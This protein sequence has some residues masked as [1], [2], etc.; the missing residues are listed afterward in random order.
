[1]LV[2]YYVFDDIF[3]LPLLRVKKHKHK[4]SKLK[5][6]RQTFF[7]IQ[8]QGCLADSLMKQLNFSEYLFQV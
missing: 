6:E 4:T 5:G 2:L 3:W 1:M 8:T 7:Y